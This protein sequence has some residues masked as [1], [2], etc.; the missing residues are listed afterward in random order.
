[1]V[2]K[3]NILESDKLK[4]WRPRLKY[5]IGA[6][7]LILLIIAVVLVVILNKSPDEPETKS[8][9][10]TDDDLIFAQTVRIIIYSQIK[11]SFFLSI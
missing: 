11:L 4:S 6:T 5:F 10:G 7:V 8:P 2:H 3:I 9:N 1:M